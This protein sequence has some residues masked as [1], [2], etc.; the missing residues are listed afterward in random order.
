MP[1]P[2]LPPRRGWAGAALLGSLL[3]TGCVP[4]PLRAQPN[5]QVRV[6]TGTVNTPLRTLT[7]EAVFAPPGP[8]RLSIRTDRAAF[9]TVIVLPEQRWGADWSNAG[10]VVLPQL[11]T[12]P[13][14]ATPVTV[15]PT[16]GFTQVYSVATLTPVDLSGAAGRRSVSEVGRAVEAVTRTLPAG[17]YNVDDLQYRVSRLGT[18]R[19]AASQPD[20]RVY[21]A[22]RPVAL[23]GFGGAVTVPN[24]PEGSVT[25]TVER[26]G[27]VTWSYPVTV[28]PNR[29]R[30]VYAEL[31]RPQ[32][33]EGVLRVTSAVRA[34]VTVGGVGVGEAGP[35]QPLVLAWRAGEYD[36]QLTAAESGE[37]STVRVRVRAGQT[38]AV[39]CTR[40][41]DFTCS[42]G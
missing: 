10:A 22:G 15:P 25:V 36:V 39:S 29:V 33:R 6:V 13:G 16:L 9:V 23:L 28:E 5:A 18:L 31:L 30:D 8:E 41:P 2:S 35:G 32:P 19:I 7:G 17:S 37:S 1:L 34:R 27:F 14:Q 4:A 3:L 24:L 38:T 20:A 11:T 21:V 42:G 12:Q 40:S 26:A